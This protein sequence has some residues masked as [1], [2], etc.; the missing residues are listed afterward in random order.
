MTKSIRCWTRMWGAGIEK[1]RKNPAESQSRSNAAALLQRSDDC[2]TEGSLAN[3]KDFDPVVNPRQRIRDHGKKGEKPRYVEL[4][5]FAQTTSFNK[6][7]H[8]WKP[9]TPHSTSC[10]KRGLLIFFFYIA[11]S[12]TAITELWQKAIPPC[13]SLASLLP[14]VPATLIHSL[15]ETGLRKAPS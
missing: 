10:S 1:V 11:L 13:F 5:I 2:A 3:T 6:H 4:K 8:F 15:V 7:L 14:S 9:W 12:K